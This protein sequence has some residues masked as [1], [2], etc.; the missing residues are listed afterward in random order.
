MDVA[1]IYDIMVYE[2]HRR[3]GYGKKMIQYMGGLIQKEGLNKMVLNV[4]SNNVAAN[5]LYESMGFTV[6]A[7]ESG[8]KAMIKYL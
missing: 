8:Q 3:A 4:F 1:F 6:I 7:E 5:A 2:N